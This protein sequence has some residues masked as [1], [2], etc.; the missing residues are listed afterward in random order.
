MQNIKQA[1]LSPVSITKLPGKHTTYDL[2]VKDR[3]R[4]YANRCLV[5]NCM[6]AY[7]P[8]GSAYGT[9]QTMVHHNVPWFVGIGNWGNLIDVAAAERYTNC[10]LS[11]VGWSCFDRDY[12]AIADMV[13]NYDGKDIELCPGVV[14]KV[15]DFPYLEKVKGKTLV[16]TDG[17]TLLGADDKAGIAAI[18]EAVDYLLHHPEVK[19]GRIAIAFTP[20]EEVGRGTE[21]F[22]TEKFGAA[23]AYTM[24]GGQIDAW[25]DETFNAASAVV[26][27]TGFSIHP[28]SA[29]DK[30][31]NALNTAIEF[32]NMLPEHSR[33]EHTENR[34]PFFHLNGLEGNVDHAKME[35]IIR[36]HD[37]AVFE[38]MK[39]EMV[40]AAEYLNLKHNNHVIDI[41]IKDSYKNMKEV[42]KDHPEASITAEKALRDIGV[43]P[44]N[45]V[46]RGGTDGS[47]L[48]FRGIPCPN[49]GNGGENF[50]GRYEY[51]VTEELEL[52]VKLIVRISE[53][54]AEE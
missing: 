35:Y 8:H 13:P 6:G 12:L 28:G 11:K 15:S 27:C 21:H 25:S 17:S 4:F 37:G 19:H 7:H 3:H 32:H 18:M 22:D 14:T 42:L 34:E 26:E 53:I 23:F 20:D 44:F 2:E 49:L 41:E 29:K 31:I 54:V 38:N 45:E 48:T 36:S 33:P 43:E 50:H 30:M 51:C 5:H 1:Y 10:C 39:K 40:A 9:I 46:I 24:D 16:V 47:A 52:A